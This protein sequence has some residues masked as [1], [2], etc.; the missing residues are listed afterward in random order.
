MSKYKKFIKLLD[1]YNNTETLN[2]PSANAMNKLITNDYNNT[3]PT[4]FN[5]YL[6]SNVQHN[7]LD[8]DIYNNSI[9]LHFPPIN[10]SNSLSQ[11]ALWQKSVDVTNELDLNG[12]IT[13]TPRIEKTKTCHIDVSVNSIHDLLNIVDT[14]SFQLDTEY[15]IDLEVLHKIKPELTLL[16]NMIGM[17]TLKHSVVNQLLYFIQN[18]HVGN[19]VGDF[20]HTVIYGPPGTGK[21]EVARIIGQ[22][23]S[24]IGILK[25]NTFRKVTRNDLIAGYLGQTAI[26][27][28][29][30]INDCLG[31]VLFIDEAYS[32]ASAD[33]SDSFSKECLDIL[34]EALSEHKDD[35]MVI[36]AGYENELNSSFFG[37][38][39]GLTSRF[40]WRFSMQPYTMNELNKI[41][42]KMVLDQEWSLDEKLNLPDK[43]FADRK[44]NFK[45][46]GR[47]IEALITYTKIAHGRRIYGNVSAN[48]KCIT[49]DDLNAGYK[50]FS[51]N[52]QK[53]EETTTVFGLYV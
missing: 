21:T 26:K 14:H 1:E 7:V 23:Y 37:A 22:M 49:L 50:Q 38:N 3:Y 35:L 17:D 51:A 41:F 24:K 39:P 42:N 45:N 29:Q 19:K 36:I 30:V 48:K 52:K 40:I 2:K 31:G 53:K 32:L 9:G 10:I 43:W 8:N 44:D 12:I 18:L 6:M 11:Y 16:N 20:K 28:K 34:C 15:N 25:K 27:T 46:C 47:D 4:Y 5:P 33:H 13:N